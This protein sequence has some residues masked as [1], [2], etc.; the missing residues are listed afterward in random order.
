[1]T[2]SNAL[3]NLKRSIQRFI[4]SSKF[5]YDTVWCTDKIIGIGEANKV[6][7]KYIFRRSWCL[8][9]INIS[10]YCSRLLTLT[11]SNFVFA[12]NYVY[13]HRKHYWKHCELVHGLRIFMTGASYIHHCSDISIFGSYAIT[14]CSHWGPFFHRNSNAMQISLYSHPNYNEVI[15]VF[16]SHD[17]TAVLSWNVQNF[18]ALWYRIMEVP[19]SHFPIGFDLQWKNRLWIGPQVVLNFFPGVDVISSWE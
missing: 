18:M 11:F 1:M 16:F 13:I 6:V 2:S 14:I 5:I 12:H 4:L 8:S 10:Q 15:A 3:N 7:E 9:F 17:T 19:Y